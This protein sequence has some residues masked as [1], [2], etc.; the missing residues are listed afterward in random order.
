MKKYTQGS[1]YAQKPSNRRAQEEKQNALLQE[2][3]RLQK[4][5]AQAK[6]DIDEINKEV[7]RNL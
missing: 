5:L 3:I 1:K 6:Q 2:E 7:E 4:E